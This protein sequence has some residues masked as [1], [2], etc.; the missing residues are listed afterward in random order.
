MVQ[1][2]TNENS[3][4]STASLVTLLNAGIEQVTSALG[5]ARVN[6]TI[7][8]TSGQN[9]VTLP[10]DIQDL[11]SVSFSTASPSASGTIVYPLTQMEQRAFMDF[12]G[13]MPGTS[14]GPPVAYFISSDVSNVQTM[15]LYP[16]ATT[17]QLNTYYRQRPQL[18]ADATSAST[19]SI[20]SQAQEAMILWTCARLCESRER[21]QIAGVFQQQ[22][23][24]KIEELRDIIQ[25]RTTPKSGQV[26]DV[27][28]M[29]RPGMPP[30]LR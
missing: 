11:I 28:S 2:R 9:V 17:G 10:E 13:G 29:G 3:L 5:P 19:T 30:W 23:D 16:A 7:V 25:R 27:M 22:Y 26:R 15:Q 12:A 6:G 24:A 4:P 21:Y 18:F 8:L 14:F 1:L 20:D